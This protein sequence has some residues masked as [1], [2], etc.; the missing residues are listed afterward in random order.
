MFTRLYFEIPGFFKKEYHRREAD[1]FYDNTFGINYK[2][3]DLIKQ[4]LSLNRITVLT[5][6]KDGRSSQEPIIY[7]TN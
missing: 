4:P 7:L 2:P 1:L 5:L 6:A 3:L